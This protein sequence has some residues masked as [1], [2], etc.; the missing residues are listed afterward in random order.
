[1]LFAK[2]LIARDQFSCIIIFSKTD[3][4]KMRL[5]FY[6]PRN[7]RRQPCID[8]QNGPDTT[9]PKSHYSIEG[10]FDG[11]H[12]HIYQRGYENHQFRQDTHNVSEREF[13]FQEVRTLQ[14]CARQDRGMHQHDAFFQ[15]DFDA[16]ERR[17]TYNVY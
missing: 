2:W 8:N 12:H 6:Y 10:H 15:T 5:E 17:H 16:V 11:R 4:E 9:D 14:L 13:E 3:L 1:L 7:E